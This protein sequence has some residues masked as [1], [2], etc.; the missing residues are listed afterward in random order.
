VAEKSKQEVFSEALLGKKIP[1]LTL[2]NK[3]YRLLDELGR[4]SVKDW[5][6]QLNKLLKRQ[7]KLNTET[8]EIKKLKKKLMSEIVPMVDEME[9]GGSKK[10]E[11]EIEEHK[12]LIAEC[13]EKLESYQ[14]ELIELPREIDKI[15]IQLMVFTME[16]CYDT[17]QENTKQIQAISDWV[18]KIRVELKK[19]LVRKQEMEQRNHDIYA[20]MND[21]F[22]ADVVNLFDLQYNPEEQHPV[23]PGE[24][25]KNIDDGQ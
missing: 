16:Y 18:T 17:M 3:W 11:K 4:E 24:K 19:N 2:D 14:E 5:E 23:L 20:Y 7:G 15:N 8:K 25:N 22:G 12:R 6:N 1:M 21:I 13:N 10:L 9:Q